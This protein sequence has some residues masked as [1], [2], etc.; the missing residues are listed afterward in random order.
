M[1]SQSRA[2]AHGPLSSH[3]SAQ[4]PPYAAVVVTRTIFENDHTMRRHVIGGF[5]MTA[6]IFLGWLFHALGRDWFIVYLLFGG[7][8]LMA[9]AASLDGRA[10]DRDSGRSLHLSKRKSSGSGALR[11]STAVPC[12]QSVDRRP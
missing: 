2:L 5:L 8:L 9:V 12:G 7:A 3:G 1:L 11:E 6:S 10:R 4:E